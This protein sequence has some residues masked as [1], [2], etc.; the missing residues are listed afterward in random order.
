[1]ILIGDMKFTPARKQF[2]LVAN[3]FDWEHSENG[4]ADGEP[5]LRRRTGLHFNQVTA[6]RAQ[7]IRQ[8][9]NDAVLELLSI[10][11]EAAG[12]AVGHDLA[13]IC[14]RRHAQARCR[15]ASKPR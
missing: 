15:N 11:F 5:F 7:N 13:D 3:R 2:A 9:E 1:M 10:T 12:S 6:A 14:R 4:R 8:G